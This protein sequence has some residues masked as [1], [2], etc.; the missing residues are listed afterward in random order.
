MSGTH[1]Q[2]AMDVLQT[3]FDE[4]STDDLYIQIAIESGHYFVTLGRRPGTD[5]TDVGES[6]DS[7]VDALDQALDAFVAGEAAE[8]AKKRAHFEAMRAKGTPITIEEAVKIFAGPTK[9]TTQ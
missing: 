6:D 8:E 7:L 9:E 2:R 3:I 4:T 1:E 5:Y